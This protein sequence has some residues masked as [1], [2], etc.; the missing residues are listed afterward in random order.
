MNIL[1][2]L[3]YWVVG[4]WNI[5]PLTIHSF[6]LAVAIGLVIGF[7]L[8][9]RRA[10]RGMGVSGEFA[11][12]FGIWLLVIGWI[13]AHVL[14]VLFYEPH[15]VLEDPLI[16]FKVWGSI[17]S[18][19]GLIGGILATFIWHRR[20]PDK[21]LLDWA[22]LGAF[23]LPF[24]WLWGRIGCAMV[25]DHPGVRAEGFWLWEQI[26][27][28]GPE[29]LPEIWP[30]AMQFPDG[31]RHDLGLYEAIWWVFIVAFC[32]IM[33]RKPRRRG[34]YLWTL[35]LL[36]APARFALDFLRVEPNQVGTAGDIRYFGLTPGHYISVAL[37]A[38]G[39]VLWLRFRHLP[40]EVWVRYNPAKPAETN[41]KK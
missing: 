16:L 34:F 10:E 12:N 24:C 8:L 31:P 22:N 11:Q 41:D 7:S 4:P 5:G 13:S 2:V 15:M 35:P 27:A 30:L 19:G 36:Y 14:D 21:N 25:H 38:L 40:A 18:Y 33:D 39:I 20:N 3:P 23:S 32:L 6:G 17:S 1:G 26:K 28:I 37:F 9:A 29:S